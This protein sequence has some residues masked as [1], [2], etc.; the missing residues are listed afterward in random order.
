MDVIP[1]TLRGA[2]LTGRVCRGACGET[3]VSCSSCCCW[4]FSLGDWGSADW[5]RCMFRGVNGCC[6]GNTFGIT[7]KSMDA[8]S[9]QCTQWD[10]IMPQTIT[11]PSYLILQSI[12]ERWIV[13]TGATTTFRQ[14]SC[15]IWCTQRNPWQSCEIHS[16]L[17]TTG[18]AQ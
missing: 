18:M 13:Y 8:N 14:Y 7:R 15:K 4:G 3:V 6:C 11:I 10:P 1:A 9:L 5:G 16:K 2:A 12:Q 17:E